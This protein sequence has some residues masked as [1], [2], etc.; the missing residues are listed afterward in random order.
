VLKAATVAPFEM[1][2]QL[3]GAADLNRP[4]DL[5]V[6]GGQAMRFAVALPVVAK[7]IGQFGAPL[8]LSCRLPMRAR[9]HR[10]TA[11]LLR[12]PQ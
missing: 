3:S 5:S 4:H 10:D 9:Q 1:P 7:D 12:P 6:R 11:F 8:V 2:S